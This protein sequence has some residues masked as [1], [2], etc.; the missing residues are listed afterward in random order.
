MTD[1][2]FARRELRHTSLLQTRPLLRALPCRRR[3][4]TGP[5]TRLAGP[6]GDENP[7]EKEELGL[8][9]L[10]PQMPIQ[11]P[12]I[13]PKTPI[14]ELL[15][16]P[17]RGREGPSRDRRRLDAGAGGTVSGSAGQG[18]P[19][20]ACSRR[21]S[22]WR[23]ST[24]ST[25]ARRTAS[26]RPWWPRASGSGRTAPLAM[27]DA[28]RT[29]GRTQ[30]HQFA[31]A[32]ATVRQARR[33]SSRHSSPLICECFLQPL[34][35][36]PTRLARCLLRL[37]SSATVRERQQTNPVFP[38]QRGRPAQ[39]PAA[40]FWTQYQTLCDQQDAAQARVDKEQCRHITL[41]RIA[42]LDADPR[43][44]IAIVASGSGQAASVRR[45]P[46]RGHPR[47]LVW[48]CSPLRTSPSA[49]GRCRCSP[50]S[51]RT[52]LHGRPRPWPALSL[53]EGVTQCRRRHRPSEARGPAAPAR[54]LAGRRG[55]ARSGGSGGRHEAGA[56]G[57]RD[58][59]DQSSSQ[60][61]PVSLP[62][63]Q[64][65]RLQRDA[66]RRCATNPTSRSRVLPA[67]IA[68]PRSETLVRI[69]VTYLRQDFYPMFQ[70]VPD[71]NPLAGDAAVRLPRPHCAQLAAEEAALGLS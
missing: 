70:A 15:P 7:V 24:T 18:T 30:S 2:H 3:A 36:L 61:C 48:P 34:K 28:C 33:P 66:H 5:E 58:G 47:W 27:G 22:S 25:A 71:A 38:Y 64:R 56:G 39:H 50:G 45:H 19:W 4:L 10:P 42:A 67:A 62:W 65:R 68:I 53:A 40:S 46:P 20:Y 12:P 14:K 1:G 21:P 60:L 49:S 43:S 37:P 69:D 6:P 54:G 29:K 52:R 55:P 59:A 32:V 41:A 26:S 9:S 13:D 57:Q 35:L 23:R 44:R 8:V 17:P 11:I 63:H 16:T 51:P 31:Q